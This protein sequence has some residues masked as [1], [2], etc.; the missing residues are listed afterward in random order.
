MKPTLCILVITAT[1]LWF[2]LHAAEFQ[3]SIPKATWEPIFFEPINELSRRAGWEPLR[4]APV[5]EGALEVRVW[6]G[7]GVVPLEGYR[8]R[9]EGDRWTGTHVVDTFE[10][11]SPPAVRDVT[12]KSGWDSLWKRL[13]G[14]RL[15]TLPDSTTLR[16]DDEIILDGESYVVE[17]NHA[18][19]YR[20]YEYGNPD[21]RKFPEAKD[22]ASIGWL[23]RH[24]LGSR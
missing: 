1:S 23:L 20:T 10:R 4:N 14:C 11:R 13:T 7:F 21:L 12:P 18:G 2:A 15:L 9:R 24:E 16:R 22:M 5:G 8:L 3:R 17:I 6:I 19:H